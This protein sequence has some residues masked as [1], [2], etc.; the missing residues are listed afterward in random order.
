MSETPVRL[1]DSDTLSEILRARNETVAH[2]ATQYLAR[3]S[4]FTF[5]LI[6]RF[7]TLRGLKAKNATAPWA[8]FEM[9]CAESLIFPI[10][11]EVIELAADLYADLH[12]RGEL[13]GDADLLIAAT[14]LHH[15]LVLVT[16]NTEHFKRIP[17]LTIENWAVPVSRPPGGQPDAPA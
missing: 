5:S 11:E 14:A 17:G 7:E 8:Q 12:R 3:N 15:E 10:S 6:T 1:L 13:I 9:R 4:C 2:R 16:R